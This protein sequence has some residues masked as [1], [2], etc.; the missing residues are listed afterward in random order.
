M[1][2]H[3]RAEVV[4]LASVAF[5]ACSL[6]LLVAAPSSGSIVAGTGLLTGLLVLCLVR[7]GAAGTRW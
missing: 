1:V 2:P 3:A 5:C 6:G 7:R 4:T